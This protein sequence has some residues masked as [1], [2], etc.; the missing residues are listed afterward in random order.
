MRALRKSATQYLQTVVFKENYI[1]DYTVCV[2][3]NKIKKKVYE[4]DTK[5]KYFVGETLEDKWIVYP[6]D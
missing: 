3:H 1:E 4:Y 2:I 6:W 5:I